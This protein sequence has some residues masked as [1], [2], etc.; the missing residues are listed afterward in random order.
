[1]KS[2]NWITSLFVFLIWR[3][4]FCQTWYIW[5]YF[6]LGTSLTEW[7]FLSKILFDSRFLPSLSSILCRIASNFRI[8]K[9]SI[10]ELKRLNLIYCLS[11]K[12]NIRLFRFQI[13]LTQS[14]LFTLIIL[15]YWSI[16]HFN[17]NQLNFYISWVE[18]RLF[19]FSKH[20]QKFLFLLISIRFC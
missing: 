8:S 7:K 11:C 10:R 19:L 17:F 15:C 5:K 2:P 13:P 6:F 3:V 9:I 16:F 12:M 4:L 14:L 20:L 1:M 18:F